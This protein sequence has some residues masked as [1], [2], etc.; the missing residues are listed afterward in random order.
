MGLLGDW[1]ESENRLSMLLEASPMWSNGFFFFF[2]F[3]HDSHSEISNL[4]F[5][6]QVI[7]TSRFPND[8]ASRFVKEKDFDSW[9]DNLHIFAADFR[10]ITGLLPFLILCFFQSPPFL[11]LLFC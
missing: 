8:T 3:L 1:R 2:F 11:S 6:P 5:S 4:P 9:K 7:C 10:N